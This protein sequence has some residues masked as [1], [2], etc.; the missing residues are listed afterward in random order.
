VVVRVDAQTFR[1]GP[2]GH[3]RKDSMTGCCRGQR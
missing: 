3:E 1:S 2:I